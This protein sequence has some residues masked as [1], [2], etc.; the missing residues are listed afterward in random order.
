MSRQA[1]RSWSSSSGVG[2]SGTSLLDRDPRPARLPHPAARGA[3]RRH[4]PARL[5]RAALGGRLPHPAA[6]PAAGHR[7]RLAPGRLGARRA[8]RRDPGGARRAARVARRRSSRQADAVVV[9]DPRTVWF[10]PLW[11]RCAA[12]PRRRALVRDDAAPPGRDPR[13]ARAS[14]TGPGRARR[15]APRRGSTSRSRPSARRA[16]RGA[17]SCATR[18]CWPT[19]AR[20]VTRRRRA[21]RPAAAA[22]A[23]TGAR[24]PRST[25]SSTRRCTATA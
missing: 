10:L 16:A 1:R 6:A 13:P 17:R 4:Q 11:M 20:E 15:A 5:R 2:R 22:R 9:K 7:Q 14:P 8:R 24:R 23:S 3:G 18:T 25:S 21:A 19:G 12:R